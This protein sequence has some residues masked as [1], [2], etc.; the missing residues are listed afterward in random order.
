[1]IDRLSSLKNIIFD[2][3]G[4]IL[5]TVDIKTKVF[6]SLYAHE[7]LDFQE[8]VVKYHLAHGG[9]SRVKKIEHFE[10]VLSQGDQVCENKIQQKITEFTNLN[11]RKVLKA[12]FIPGVLEFIKFKSN[13]SQLF[14]CS[15]VP[16]KELKLI[17]KKKKLE[18][19]FKDIFGSPTG[20]RDIILSIIDKYDL[21]SSEVVFIG[22]SMTDYQAAIETG[23]Q[24]IGIKNAFT[25]FPESVTEITSFDDL[26]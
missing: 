2:F 24:F 26:M 20:K 19:Y 25:E 6:S 22:D 21:L 8:Y 16:E 12:D 3:D 1:M 9:I 13:K 14:V 17:I 4:V 15:G 7:S 10:E 23:I 18:H 5:D 11:L